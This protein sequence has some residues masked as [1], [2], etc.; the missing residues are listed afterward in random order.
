MATTGNR[1]PRRLP[2]GR[3]RL[4]MPTQLP[5][6]LLLFVPSGQVV[7]VQTTFLSVA[8]FSP[9]APVSVAP[10]GW[11]RIVAQADLASV[12]V[13]GGSVQRG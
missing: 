7:L 1:W 4:K 3:V 2:I 5:L 11:N 6:S 12:R 8:V 10:L 13:N 9:V